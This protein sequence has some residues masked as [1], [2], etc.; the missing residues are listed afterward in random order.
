M[1]SALRNERKSMNTTPHIKYVSYNMYRLLYYVIII[2][3]INVHKYSWNV[4]FI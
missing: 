2:N 3:V 4:Y 1:Y